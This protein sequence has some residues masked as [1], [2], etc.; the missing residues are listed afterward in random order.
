MAYH[1][2]IVAFASSA[3]RSK[4]FG[5]LT[6]QPGHSLPSIRDIQA[7]GGDTPPIA[8]NRVRGSYLISDGFK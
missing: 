4:K 7:I 8:G 1:E 2:D 6:N 5:V 3:N